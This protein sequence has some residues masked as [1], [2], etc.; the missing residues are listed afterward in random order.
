MYVEMDLQL[1]E[2]GAFD[3]MLSSK[4]SAVIHVP[5]HRFYSGGLYLNC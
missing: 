5:R 1:Q 3:V 2:V 4:Q